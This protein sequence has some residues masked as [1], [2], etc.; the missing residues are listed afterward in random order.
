MMARNRKAK[1]LTK[2]EGKRRPPGKVGRRR[3][4]VKAT[5]V[6]RERNTAAVAR[7]RA[8]GTKRRDRDAYLTIQSSADAILWRLRYLLG[9]VKKVLEPSA[10]TGNL[11]RAAKEVWPDAKIL[12]VDLF[13]KHHVA[14]HKAGAT[15]YII[16]D[17]L[18]QDVR[19]FDADVSVSNPPF[20]DAERHVE[21]ALA[22]L[23][24][25]A[26]HVAL[27]PTTFLCAQRRARGLYANVEPVLENEATW[28]S[29]R[30]GEWGPLRWV[31]P[32]AE[33]PSFT[34]DG[35]TDMVEYAVFIFQK[36][37][38]GGASLLAHC[39]RSDATVLR[40]FSRRA[41][42]VRKRAEVEG[43]RLCVCGDTLDRHPLDGD[44]GHTQCLD[45]ACTKFVAADSPEG[46]LRKA[47]ETVAPLVEAERPT[48]GEDF[49]GQADES[50]FD[51][52]GGPKDPEALPV[53]REGER[54]NEEQVVVEVCT[55][56]L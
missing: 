49:L 15:S 14:L 26:Y 51:T 36:G 47:H 40:E 9:P 20:S 32:I 25:G 53:P 2:R 39:W 6:P 42:A 17:F 43:R 37:W 30:R 28:P 52:A 23:R 24:D 38:T 13:D 5:Q 18:T 35:K 22:Q 55:G 41:E 45:C 12:A 50:V 54:V 31:M 11:V 46:L 21:H 10:G 16:G 8:K 33:R 7:S 48:H 27:L 44:A 3:P 1:R 19:G 4:E 34:D 29:Q 56:G